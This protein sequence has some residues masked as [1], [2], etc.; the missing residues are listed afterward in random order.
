M[1]GMGL[2]VMAARKCR[3]VH[4]RGGSSQALARSRWPGRPG[5]STCY[6]KLR[7]ITASDECFKLSDSVYCLRAK[8]SVRW[9]AD[10]WR[11]F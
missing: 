11:F 4:M 6:L 10:C 1:I 2:I 8:E 7:Y 3:A 5:G 9:K